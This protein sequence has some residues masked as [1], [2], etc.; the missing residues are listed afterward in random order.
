[1]TNKTLRKVVMAAVALAVMVVMLG[2]YTRLTDAGLGCPDWPGCYG[3][4]TVPETVEHIELAEAAYPERPVEPHKAWNEMIHRY[5]AS[6]LGF[7]ILVIFIGSITRKREQGPK[8]L[9]MFLLALVLFQGALGMWTVTMNLMPLVVM[10]HLLGGFTTLT[11]LFV[12]YLRLTDYQVP[13]GDVSVRPL[14]TASLVGLIIL[15]AQIALG[16]WTAANYAAVACTQLPVCEGAWME[17]ITLSGAFSIPE[18][19][20]YEFGAHNYDA[21]MTIHVLHRIGAVIT[22]VYL[23]WLAAKLNAAAMT[24]FFKR[25]SFLLG[26]TVMVQ[27]LLGVGNVVLKLPISVAVVHNFVAVVLAMVLSTVIYSIARKA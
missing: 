4:I 14:L 20:N 11:L 19:D 26:L 13:G 18:A 9:P 21:R 5:F 6:T 2:S 7:L 3:F 10:G 1:M 27:F 15:I 16:G 8:K 17:K 12:L 23:L 25:L 24:P 22:V